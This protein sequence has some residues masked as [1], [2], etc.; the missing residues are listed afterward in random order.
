MGGIAE[1]SAKAYRLYKEY[2]AGYQNRSVIKV[3]PPGQII[4][5]KNYELDYFAFVC[6]GDHRAIN[7]FENGNVYMMEK[8]EAIDFVGE[9]TILAGQERTS[10]TLETITECVLLQ[11]PRKDFERWIK[12]DIDLL[13]L[14]AS[15][16][17]F[18]LYRSSVKEWGDTVLSAELSAPGVSGAVR[19]QAYDGK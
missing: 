17:A 10:V 8:N 1:T 13:Y 3:I 4:H 2:A 16:V 6:C 5:Q 15:K 12:E 7:E 18:K 9:V 19:R 11:M 14:I